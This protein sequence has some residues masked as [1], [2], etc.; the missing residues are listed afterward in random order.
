LE[1]KRLIQ[2]ATE[3]KIQILELNE[4]S[5]E[6]IDLINQSNEDLIEI[7][8][9]Y[10]ETYNQ[11]F[12]D[13]SEILRGRFELIVKDTIV[14]LN[15][16]QEYLKQIDINDEIIQIIIKESIYVKSK[17]NKQ[18]KKFKNLIFNKNKIEFIE[19]FDVSIL[20]FIEYDKCFTVR[21][22]III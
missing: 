1:Q 5:Q 10:E 12:L 6:E 2:L 18:L 21:N 14:F 16:K 22:N 20:G 3:L 8:D 9:N 13:Q 11:D 17:L 19:S 4:N 7:I 15:Q